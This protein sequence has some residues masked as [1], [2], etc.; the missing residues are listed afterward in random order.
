M[1]FID[2]NFIDSEYRESL[3]A[4]RTLRFVCI[5]GLFITPLILFFWYPQFGYFEAISCIISVFIFLS[6]LIS[7]IVSKFVK[8]NAAYFL[9]AL[10]IAASAGTLFFAY[11]KNFMNLQLYLIC[12][13]MVITALSMRNIKFIGIYLAVMLALTISV[14]YLLKDP[15]VNREKSVV[16]LI[17]FIMLSYTNIKFRSNYQDIL[18]EKEEHYRALVEISPQAIFVHYNGK[19]IYLNPNALKLLGASNIEEIINRPMLD[20]IHVD[21]RE[22]EINR[23]KNVLIDIEDSCVEQILVRLDGNYVM[24][25][26]NLRKIKFNNSQAIIGIYNDISERKKCEIQLIEAES[27]YRNLV[28]SAF[29]GVFLYENNQLVYINPYLEHLL[30]YSLEELQKIGLINLFH[31]DDKADV[32]KTLMTST[33]KTLCGNYHVRV[34]SKQ[35]EMIY[36]EVSIAPLNNISFLGTVLN[37]TNQKKAEEQ[38][39]HMAYYDMLTSLPNRQMLTDYLSQSIKMKKNNKHRIAVIFIDL[40]RFKLINDTLGH[41]YGD[42]LLQE[43]AQRLK[44]CVSKNDIVSRYGGDEFVIIVNNADENAISQVCS[45][46]LSQFVQPFMLGARE[47]YTTPSIGISFYPEDGQDVD[48]LIKHADIAMYR[49]K[50]KGKNNFQFYT[51]SLNKEVSR[52]MDLE[53]SLRKALTNNEFV[54]HYQPQF[55]LKTGLIYGLEALIRWENPINGL[56]SPMEFIPLCEETGLIIPIGEWVIETACR[57][58]KIWREAG[59]PFNHIGINVSPK[60]LRHPGFYYMLTDVLKKLEMDPQNLVIEVTESV[61][62]DINTSVLI[63]KLISSGIRVAID[64]FGTGYSSLRLLKNFRPSII[65]IDPSFIRDIVKNNDSRIILKHIL[66]MGHELNCVIIAEGIEY[67]EQKS[68]LNTLGCDIG[69]GYLF[70]KPLTVMNVEMFYNDKFKYIYADNLI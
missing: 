61:M 11:V 31:D 6:L 64:D 30:G 70:S 38:I 14:L 59:Y 10:Y 26:S 56:V 50:D 32:Q 9:A 28:E 22:A 48:T 44:K 15:I 17:I 36:I 53:T 2:F 12:L 58:S 23:I 41:N 13:L 18:K 1:D 55:D 62:Q 52:Q 16:I 19:I 65:K 46:I 3:I 25:E 40:D 47:V 29:I 34:S 4:C 63:N 24:V 27:R 49:A 20:F 37:I 54:L 67:E 45:K 42:K 33:D 39:M 21:Y 57:Q 35:G 68:L 7:S 60:Q 8:K 43:A 5:V 69:Q 51:F 66:N